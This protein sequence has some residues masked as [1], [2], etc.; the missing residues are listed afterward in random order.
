MGSPIS[1]RNDTINEL[2]DHRKITATSEDRF[3]FM[4]I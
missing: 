1:S 3:K 4:D 2:Y